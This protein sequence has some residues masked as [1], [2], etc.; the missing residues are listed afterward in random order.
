[1]ISA[2][3]DKIYLKVAHYET[4]EDNADLG[5]LI[6][7]SGFAAVEVWARS[8][9]AVHAG[10]QGPI[11]NGS[12]NFQ[13]NTTYGISSDGHTVTFKPYGP[14]A[15]DLGTGNVDTWQGK[16]PN[17]PFPPGTVRQSYTQAEIDDTWI[18]EKAAIDAIMNNPPP[19][20]FIAAEG[21]N[22]D[23]FFS[24][25]GPGMFD[26]GGGNASA[27]VT[28]STMS[29]GTEF[30]LIANPVAGLSV[31]FN[32]SHTEAQRTSIAQ[33]YLDYLNKRRAFFYGPAGDMRIWDSGWADLTLDPYTTAGNGSLSVAFRSQVDSPI[34]LFL[35]SENT[36]VPELKPWAFN[37]VANYAF[38]S[39][40]LRG[41]N[42]G[43]GYRW[44]DRNIIGYPIT[45]DEFGNETYDVANPYYGPTE[46]AVDLWAGYERK[47]WKRYKWRLQLNV[48]N[49]FANDKLIKAS[50]NPD[51]SGA[52]YRIPEPRT[53]TLTSSIEF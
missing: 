46:A 36:K 22:R 6:N 2:L 38:Q 27:V 40:Q 11:G 48:R 45:T 20:S 33:S 35:A 16:L 12:S 1:V 32:A 29:K 10:L 4:H 21:I 17:E 30:E 53:F 34:S 19:D 5:D 18:R 9:A 39:E 52:A 41:L 15:R 51:G 43:G 3:N 7:P 31:A 14:W 13:A 42:V 8:A 50:A 49:A 26:Y 47:F 44:Q 23:T 28:G 25:T 37:L 24:P